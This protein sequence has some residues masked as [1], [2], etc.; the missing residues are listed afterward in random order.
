[1]SPAAIELVN[2]LSSARTNLTTDSIYQMHWKRLEAIAVFIDTN[3]EFI[4]GPYNLDSF[5]IK[6]KFPPGGRSLWQQFV[7]YYNYLLDAAKLYLV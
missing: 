2:L 1:M 5:Y 4:T 3:R 7:E 6:V